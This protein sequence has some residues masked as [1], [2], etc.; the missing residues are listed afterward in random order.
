MVKVAT[1]GPVLFIFTGVQEL[2]QT[3][4]V[5]NKFQDTFFFVLFSRQEL[6]RV[7]ITIDDEEQRVPTR[8]SVAVPKI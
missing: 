7:L 5:R 3:L 6:L 2:T 4:Q 8:L 1:L